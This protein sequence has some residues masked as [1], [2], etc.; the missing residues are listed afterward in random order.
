ME[1]VLQQMF[2]NLVATIPHFPKRILGI[3]EISDLG[4]EVMEMV[5]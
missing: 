4:N 5:V 2:T 1:K 3:S